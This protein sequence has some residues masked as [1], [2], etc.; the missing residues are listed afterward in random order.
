VVPRA[1]LHDWVTQG[2]FH[3]IASC[4]LNE[5][6]R[7]VIHSAGLYPNHQKVAGCDV[8]WREGS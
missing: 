5:E 2:R 6:Q 3:T 7:E 8:Y 4:W 1:Q